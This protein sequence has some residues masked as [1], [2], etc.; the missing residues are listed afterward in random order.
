MFVYN[1]LI[2]HMF[3]ATLKLFGMVN[4][5]IIRS[6]KLLLTMYLKESIFEARYYSNFNCYTLLYD[7]NMSCQKQKV[8]SIV[9]VGLL[10]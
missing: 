4:V 7:R 8:E 3:Y 9:E 2:K 6:S 5:T 1:N 10:T